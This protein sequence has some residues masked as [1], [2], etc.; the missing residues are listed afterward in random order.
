[1]A[2][3][4]WMPSVLPDAP[5]L[6]GRGPRRRDASCLTQVCVSGTELSALQKTCER[7]RGNADGEARAVR[8]GE[9]LATSATGRLDACR[10]LS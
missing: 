3:C 6:H 8:C 9:R 1:M 10:A 4:R 2:A 7:M 5:R